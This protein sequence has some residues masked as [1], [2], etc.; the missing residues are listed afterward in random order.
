MEMAEEAKLANY[1]WW[2]KPEKV[3]WKKFNSMNNTA[4]TLTDNKKYTK[5]NEYE[6]LLAE[7][8]STKSIEYEKRLI[9]YDEDYKDY[10]PYLDWDR[11]ETFY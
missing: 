2:N 1:R 7:E 10:D 11:S 3:Q 4:V 5:V 6:T 8:D 9:D